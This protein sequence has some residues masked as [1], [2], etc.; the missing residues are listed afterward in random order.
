M[1]EEQELRIR[2]EEE[3]KRMVEEEQVPPHKCI[4]RISVLRCCN[5]DH[6]SSEEGHGFKQSL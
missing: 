6:F 3:R 2:L 5:I 1:E 4:I